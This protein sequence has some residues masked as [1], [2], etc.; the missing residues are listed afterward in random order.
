MLLFVLESIDP[1]SF[2]IDPTRDWLNFKPGRFW[3][4]GGGRHKLE[5]MTKDELLDMVIVNLNR[6]YELHR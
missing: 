1:N 6:Q 5:V 2:T 4:D 3:Q